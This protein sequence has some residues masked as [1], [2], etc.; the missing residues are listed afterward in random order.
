M[1]AS[2]HMNNPDSREARAYRKVQELYAQNHAADMLLIRIKQIRQ[3]V[4][5]EATDRVETAENILNSPSN[6][7]S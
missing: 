2:I 5:K 1:P 6:S 3:R 7:K 4:Q